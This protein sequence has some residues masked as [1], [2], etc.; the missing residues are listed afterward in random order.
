MTRS[1]KASVIDDVAAELALCL[2]RSR[3]MLSISPSIQ[4]TAVWWSRCSAFMC[5]S[6]G[7]ANHFHL[8]HGQ[9]NAPLQTFPLFQQARLPI[10]QR[11][12]AHLFGGLVVVEF[13]WLRFLLAPPS[14]VT[15]VPLS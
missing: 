6:V 3:I 4:L 7:R 14:V 8:R 5:T 13:F 9:A 10:D 1:M 11:L 12:G 15:P 2:P